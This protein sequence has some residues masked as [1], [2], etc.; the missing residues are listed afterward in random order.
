MENGSSPSDATT[1]SNESKSDAY[2]MGQ[3]AYQN[4]DAEGLKA[5]DHNDD[6]SKARLKRAFADNE[7]MMDVV[8]KAY[9]DGKDM[10]QF[11][12]RL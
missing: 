4:G 12:R 2:V 3:N 5:I 1:A 7:A 10:E 8:V 11:E 9:E 6:V